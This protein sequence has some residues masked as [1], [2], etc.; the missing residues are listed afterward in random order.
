MYCYQE[1]AI[2]KSYTILFESLQPNFPTGEMNTL[3][4]S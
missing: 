4:E 3:H 1:Q 2:I